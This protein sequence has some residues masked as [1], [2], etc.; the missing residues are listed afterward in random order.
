[1]AYRSHSNPI[2]K[3]AFLIA[4]ALAAALLGT[5]ALAAG[6]AAPTTSW[7]APDLQGTWDFRSITPFERPKEFGEQA[8]LS[9]EEVAAWEEKT[10]KARAARA[11]R[12]PVQGQG[13]VDGGYN[14]FWLDRGET[15]TGTMRTSLVVDPPDGRVPGADRGRQAPFRRALRALGRRAF[16][17][18]RPEPA[19]ALHHGVQLGTPDEP[20]ARITTSSRSS[21]L[22]RTWRFSTR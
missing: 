4:V 17:S 18:R 21:R 8:F 1:M 20:G 11:E 13:D 19:R 12:D 16:R 2:S 22:P 7:G 5:P 9:A 15:M 6:D 3:Q 10:R 14:A